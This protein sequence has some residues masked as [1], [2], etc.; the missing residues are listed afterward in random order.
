MDMK[1]VLWFIYLSPVLMLVTM[2]V[3][4]NIMWYGIMGGGP[5]VNKYIGVVLILPMIIVLLS[6]FCLWWCVRKKGWKQN[7]FSLLIVSTHTIYPIL[8]FQ[9]YIGESNLLP[10]SYR[11]WVY[12][13]APIGVVLWLLLM[14]FYLRILLFQKSFDTPK[15]S[16]NNDDVE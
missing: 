2:G 10:V 4:I 3:M 13:V 6:V 8:M 7:I 11:Y 14:L 9:N 16:N 5:I 15:Q 1:K 12:C